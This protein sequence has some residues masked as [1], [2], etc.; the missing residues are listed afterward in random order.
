MPEMDAS[1]IERALIAA[2]NEDPEALRAVLAPAPTWH[3]PAHNVLG[4]DHMGR[5][6]VIQYVKESRALTAGSL[7][8][9]PVGHARVKG[10]HGTLQVRAHARRAGLALDI[11]EEITFRIEGGLV[12]ELWTKPADVGAYDRFWAP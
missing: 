12:A 3:T 7:H 9:E 4:G 11:D 2:E 1:R 8:V 6:Q 5:E 10:D